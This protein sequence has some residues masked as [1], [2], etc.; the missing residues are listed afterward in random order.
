MPDNQLQ[1]FSERFRQIIE[2]HGHNPNS[3]AKSIGH[4]RSDSIRNFAAGRGYP[5]SRILLEIADYYPSVN[6][7]WLITGKGEPEVKIGSNQVISESL[8]SQSSS[9]TSKALERAE[10]EIETLKDYNQHL[11]EEIQRL[12]GGASSAPTGT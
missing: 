5:T 4:D 10:S 8:K 12:K 2:I 1:K 3:F 11:K 9:D 7:N 6:W